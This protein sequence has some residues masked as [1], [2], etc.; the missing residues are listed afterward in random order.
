MTNASSNQ[1]ATPASPRIKCALTITGAVL[2][3]SIAAWA[4]LVYSAPLDSVQ[5][6]IQKI[7]YVH[8]PC[9]FAAYAGFA[10]T[11]VSGGLYLWKNDERYDR[12]AVAGAEVGVLFCTLG[13]VTG[14]I[15]AKGTWGHWWAWDPRLTVT[16]LLWFIYLAYLL[17]RSFTEG[18]TR[19]ARFAAV[20]GIAGIA[21]IPLNYFAIELFG[22]AAMHPDNLERGSLGTGMGW[23][24]AAGVVTALL[25]L[26]HLLLLRVDLENRRVAANAEAADWDAEEGF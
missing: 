22:G 16:L 24:F 13:L 14:P 7:L 19:T 10:V 26:L 18:S 11:A 15:W 20:Y 9:W 23:P 12:V 2:A 5:G 6:L 17:L 8:V 3:V 21:V 25:A 1:E 4:Y